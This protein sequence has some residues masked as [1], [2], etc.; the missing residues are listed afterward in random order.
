MRGRGIGEAEE[1]GG[2]EREGEER[3]EGMKDR[4]V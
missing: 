3:E 4:E 2:D 1:K